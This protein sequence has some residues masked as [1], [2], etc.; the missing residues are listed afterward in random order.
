[1]LLQLRASEAAS[2]PRHQTWNEDNTYN[3]HVTA[4]LQKH[5]VSACA[6]PSSK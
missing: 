5:F 6:L 4:L 2:C 1:V 3:L